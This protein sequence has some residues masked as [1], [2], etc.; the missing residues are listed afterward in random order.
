MVHF[1]WW[2]RILYIFLLSQLPANCMFDLQHLAPSQ[3][4]RSSTRCFLLETF[5]DLFEFFD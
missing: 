4:Q 5:D 2:T 1:A 3:I